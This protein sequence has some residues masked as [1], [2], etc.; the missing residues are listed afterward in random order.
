[1]DESNELRSK[2][3][4]IREGSSREIKDMLNKKGTG[5]E[6]LRWEVLMSFDF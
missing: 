6:D 5:D 1:M 4:Q 2:G 3:R